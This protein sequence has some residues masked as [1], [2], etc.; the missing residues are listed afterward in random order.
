MEHNSERYKQRG[1]IIFGLNGSGKTTLGRELAR[2]M[3]FKHM[4]I[5]DYHFHESKIPYS[6]PRT[7]DECLD[8]MLIDIKK[9]DSFIISVVNGDYLGE[10]IVSMCILAVYIKAPVGVRLNVSISVDM[11]SLVSVFARVGICTNK[12]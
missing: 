11:I 6:N 2:V 7:R 3:N 10:E 4:D 9:Y 1:I 12:S 8:L 5:E